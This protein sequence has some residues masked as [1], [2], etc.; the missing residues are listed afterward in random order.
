MSMILEY[1]FWGFLAF[2]LILFAIL[3]LFGLIY[4]I[5]FE[6][7]NA[8]YLKRKDNKIQFKAE[9][10]ED[11]RNYRLYPNV[12]GH[13]YNKI[14]TYDLK[15]RV[16]PSELPYLIRVFGNNKWKTFLLE[17]PM[18]FANE[19]DFIEHVSRFQT[20]DDLRKY[21]RA[22]DNKIVWIHP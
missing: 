2:A 18:H 15:W 17:E 19:K 22:F 3:I 7:F 6:P 12:Y 14:N 8:Y 4:I 5:I 21:E 16:L 9:E 20:L 1:I 11:S 10:T 13:K